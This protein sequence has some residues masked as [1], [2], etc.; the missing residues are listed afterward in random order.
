[1]PH[2]K[3]YTAFV[4]FEFDDAWTQAAS[5]SSPLEASVQS[6]VVWN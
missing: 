5:I 6:E 2:G 4:R 1:M 3:I